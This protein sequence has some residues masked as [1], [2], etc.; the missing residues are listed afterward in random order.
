MKRTWG[1]VVDGESAFTPSCTVGNEPGVNG[2]DPST[3]IAPAGAEVCTHGGAVEVVE[4][5]TLLEDEIEDE[6][7]VITGD[8]EE[9]EVGEGKA[10][11]EDGLEV[12]G[13]GVDETTTEDEVE[14]VEAGVLM[15]EQPLEILEGKLEQAEAH[16]GSATELVARV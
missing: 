4:E 6:L 2:S 10:L 11:L 1:V 3:M 5:T 13:L 7:E 14:V 16:V 9:V 15:Q 8:E 12:L